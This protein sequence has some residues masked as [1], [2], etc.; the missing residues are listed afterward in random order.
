[1][2]GTWKSEQYYGDMADGLVNLAP[3]G[4]SVDDATKQLVQ[5]KTAQIKNGEFEPF[6]GPIKDQAGKERIAAGK[7]ASLAD[8]LSMDYFVEGVIGDIPKS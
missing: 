8:L 7:S 6:T 4:P 3:F 1:M 2:D 5:Q